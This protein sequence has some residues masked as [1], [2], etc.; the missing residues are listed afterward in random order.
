MTPRE[1]GYQ[2]GASGLN[3]NNVFDEDP[4]YDEGYGAGRAEYLKVF[5]SS[6]D[7]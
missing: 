2:D 3:S 5:A 6:E 7:G 4:A 1:V